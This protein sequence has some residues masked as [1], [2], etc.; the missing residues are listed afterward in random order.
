MIF[1]FRLQKT[2]DWITDREMLQKLEVAATDRLISAL[3]QRQEALERCLRERLAGSPEGNPAWSQWRCQAVAL[4]LESLRDLEKEKGQAIRLLERQR[5]DLT[6][7]ARTRHGLEVARRRREEIHR[8]EAA[9]REVRR[10][11]ENIQRS[12]F[13]LKNG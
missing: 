5:N 6:R 7:L 8:R 12:R 9:R 11:D 10:L 3:H 4:D 1:Q 13:A 2:L